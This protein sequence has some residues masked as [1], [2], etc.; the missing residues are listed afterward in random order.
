MK[1]NKKIRTFYDYEEGKKIKV[2]KATY[3]LSKELKKILSEKGCEKQ[4]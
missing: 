4:I 3:K 1:T 2:R